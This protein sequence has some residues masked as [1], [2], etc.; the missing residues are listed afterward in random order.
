ML[1]DVCKPRIM[2]SQQQCMRRQAVAHTVQSV[3]RAARAT[4]ASKGAGQRMDC[5]PEPA[6]I[7]LVNGADGGGHWWVGYV[8]VYVRVC[9]GGEGT[10]AAAALRQGIRSLVGE[11]AINAAAVH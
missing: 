8:R 1:L 11:G 6:Y 7:P 2:S 4:A 9:P 10:G 5:P 3:Q